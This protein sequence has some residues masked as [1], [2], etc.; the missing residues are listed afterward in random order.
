[1]HVIVDF[2]QCDGNGLCADA[3]PEVFELGEDDVLRVRAEHPAPALW[4]AT[5]IA[6]R[7][8]PKLAITLRTDA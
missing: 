6:A 2:D 7:G 5:E 8:C 1:M 3:A 4:P